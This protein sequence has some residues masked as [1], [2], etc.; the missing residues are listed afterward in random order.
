[1]PTGDQLQGNAMILVAFGVGALVALG[2]ILIILW[3]REPSKAGPSRRVSRHRKGARPHKPT[4]V[5]VQETQP[6][7]HQ[8]IAFMHAHVHRTQIQVLPVT[9]V[10]PRVEVEARV[11]K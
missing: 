4:Y 10:I 5:R 9:K 7:P 8:P 6:H 11:R 1:M 2:V 3:I